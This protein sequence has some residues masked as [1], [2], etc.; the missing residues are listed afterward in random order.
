M[1]PLITSFRH[2]HTTQIAPEPI[3]WG[4]TACSDGKV[5]F[6]LGLLVVI[7]LIECLD[8]PAGAQCESNIAIIDPRGTVVNGGFSFLAVTRLSA[9]TGCACQAAYA[10]LHYVASGEL[11][12]WKLILLHIDQNGSIAKFLKNL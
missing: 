2:Q 8:D 4:L 9:T 1:K 11:T 5:A 3:L 7:G 6:N 12:N 10:Q